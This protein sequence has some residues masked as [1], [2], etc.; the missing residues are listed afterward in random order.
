MPI[1]DQLINPDLETVFNINQFGYPP[2][3]NGK[4]PVYARI[5][6]YVKIATLEPV[7]GYYVIV[8]SQDLAPSAET[9]CYDPLTPVGTLGEYL[10]HFHCILLGELYT[11]YFLKNRK[12][13]LDDILRAHYQNIRN[14][15]KNLK[16]LTVKM[17]WGSY[18]HYVFNDA[19]FVHVSRD[20]KP[21]PSFINRQTLS[22]PVEYATVDDLFTKGLDEP[23]TTEGVLNAI[24][25]FAERCDEQ[26]LKSKYLADK[27]VNETG[28]VAIDLS[29][30][31]L[32]WSSDKDLSVE[33]SSDVG[34]YGVGFNIKITFNRV[35]NKTPPEETS[36]IAVCVEYRPADDLYEVAKSF[37]GLKSPVGN[38]YFRKR[39]VQAMVSAVNG[40]ISA[41]KYG[42]EKIG[43]LPPK[44]ER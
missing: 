5:E 33:C 12:F 13:R 9:A 11:E 25:R 21:N 3:E 31:I 14:V 23:V 35:Y 44:E 39:H 8:M 24:T 32:E 42:A 1:L 10:R 4:R 15:D 29:S 40:I 22:M 27:F 43:L 7:N 37:C 26:V 36:R 2:T 6:S 18:H 17:S 20:Y 16:S 19:N 41:T 30:A 28:K 34:N 38:L